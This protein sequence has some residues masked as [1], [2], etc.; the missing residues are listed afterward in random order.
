LVGKGINNLTFTHANWDCGTSDNVR[1][2][3]I[4][5]GTTVVYSNPNVSPLSCTQNLTHTFTV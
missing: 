2:L 3:Q 1:N 4:T 5:S